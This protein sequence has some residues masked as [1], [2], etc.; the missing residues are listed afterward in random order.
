MLLDHFYLRQCRNIIQKGNNLTKMRAERVRCTGTQIANGV[1]LTDDC[2][3][4]N[5]IAMLQKRVKTYNLSLK[6]LQLT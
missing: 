4:Q 5:A 1:R 2:S 3:R 6:H